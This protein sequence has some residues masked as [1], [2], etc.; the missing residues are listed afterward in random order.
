M[1]LGSGWNVCIGAPRSAAARRHSQPGGS[2]PEGTEYASVEF[3]GAGAAG[4]HA[5]AQFAGL[6]EFGEEAGAAYPAVT[7][8]VGSGA[9]TGAGVWGGLVGAFGLGG[10]MDPRGFGRG[11]PVGARGAGFIVRISAR[12]GT[13]GHVWT[14]LPLFGRFLPCPDPTLS[15]GRANLSRGSRLPT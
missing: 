4:R 3:G 2:V 10:G 8:G 15:Y 5:L 11:S 12:P 13:I 1:L 7:L 9:G 14:P 6:G